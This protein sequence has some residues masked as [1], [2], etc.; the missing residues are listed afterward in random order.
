MRRKSPPHCDEGGTPAR[1]KCG[2]G[3]LPQPLRQ[4]PFRHA[5]VQRLHWDAAT[6]VTCSTRS[7][8]F[9][10]VRPVACRLARKGKLYRKSYGLERDRV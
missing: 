6:I 9:C 8:S 2:Q 5:K 4:Q 3:G 10:S 1:L 7:L